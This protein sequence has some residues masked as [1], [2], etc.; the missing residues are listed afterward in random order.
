MGNLHG[1]IPTR[2]PEA[3]EHDKVEERKRV[4]TWIDGN[5]VAYEDANFTS[6]ETLSVLDVRTDLGRSAHKGYI[7]N[8]G[9]GDMKVEISFDGNTYGGLHTLRGG[10]VLDIDDFKINKIRLTYIDPTEYR[11][12][13]G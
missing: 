12:L 7:V 9:P 8:D 5:V 2:G 13:I 11:A 3:S 1:R 6:A 4:A 10:D